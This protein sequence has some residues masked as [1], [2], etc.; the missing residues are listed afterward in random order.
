MLAQ[1]LR[2]GI[3]FSLDEEKIMSTTR[4]I[5]FQNLLFEPKT[6]FHLDH[7][8]EITLADMHGNAMKLIYALIQYGVLELEANIFHYETL[9]SIYLTP[10]DQLSEK[11]LTT[12]NEI[13][14]RATF[15]PKKTSCLRLLGDLFADRG[16]N[17]W[18]TLKVLEHLDKNNVN[19]EI[20]L[21]NH[22]LE[23]IID[24]L[25]NKKYNTFHLDTEFATSIKNLGVLI[26]KELV[27]DKQVEDIF[28]NHYLP[29]LKAISYNLK[30]Q[31]D[32][33]LEIFSHAPIGFETIQSL[34]DEY[35][36]S[37][38][39]SNSKELC[40]TIDNINKNFLT[41]TKQ[42]PQ[43]FAKKITAEFK[44]KKPT[45]THRITWNRIFD[46]ISFHPLKDL[47]IKTALTMVHSH[48]SC[49]KK[50]NYLHNDV[51]FKDLDCYNSLGL[52]N[53]TNLV[54]KGP[55]GVHIS[56]KPPA[57]NFNFNFFNGI[58]SKIYNSTISKPKEGKSATY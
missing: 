15:N 13:L 12:F 16:A 7:P 31:K 36:T 46:K 14:S 50:E 47:N 55:I 17:D 22:D 49:K 27:S 48:S 11:D 4:V 21:S 30:K 19:Y 2:S 39:A 56:Y 24:I 5:E 43:N 32:K 58:K 51:H 10:V 28:Q 54:S 44:E 26:N 25:S 57:K 53:G 23:F 18:F 20:T 34:A 9:M 42:T 35:K 38:K 6:K 3:I 41:E 33:K 29:H 40:E 1:T 45:S 37:Y 8:N 52:S